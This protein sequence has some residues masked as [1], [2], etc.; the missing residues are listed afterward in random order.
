M[1][2][3]RLDQKLGAPWWLHRCP[4]SVRLP[5]AAPG[6]TQILPAE[7]GP[8]LLGFCRSMS[9]GRALSLGPGGK[10]LKDGTQGNKAIK[11]ADRAQR[12]MGKLARRGEADRHI[13]DLKPKHLFSGKRGA[14]KTDRR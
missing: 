3:L 11:M 9:R 1:G 6:L 10:G 4:L 12:R 13:P 2:L 8:M 7:P 14:G 5:C